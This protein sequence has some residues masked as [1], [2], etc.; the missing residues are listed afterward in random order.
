MFQAVI[1]DLDGTLLD[2][3]ADLCAS[4]NR[5]CA[6]R[7]WQTYTNAEFAAMVGHGMANL[8]ARFS[9][10]ELTDAER[11]A[12]LSAFLADYRDHCTDLTRPYPGIPELLTEV[13]ARGVKCAVFS[14]KADDLTRLIIETLLP[15]VFTI[16]RGKLP[17]MPTKP[18][19]AGL[20]PVLAALGTEKAD[21]L[22]VGDSG[23]DMQTAQNATLPSCGVTWGYRSRESLIENGAGRIAE[24]AAA[25][26]EII[27]A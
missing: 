10:P 15:P 2:T 13:H 27:F 25:L 19:P 1:F 11:A 22:Y 9:P 16:V 21:T 17:D 8:V 6:A 26:R 14:N 20:A 5:I 23:T 3:I 18:D 12:V 24:D 7:S 4:G